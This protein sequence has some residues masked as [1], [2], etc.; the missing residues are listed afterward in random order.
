MRATRMRYHRVPFS[1]WFVA[2]C[3]V[4]ILC[5]SLV[6]GSSSQVI[7]TVP[8]RLVAI[9][10]VHGDYDALVA[11]LQRTGLL[12]AKLRWSGGNAVLV[13]VGD[14]LDRGPKERPV[15]DLLMRLEREA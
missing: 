8:S 13:Q 11:M 10:D 14:F 9:G 2:T 1:R 3:V 12:D 5:V 6:T 4:A 15:M 7:P